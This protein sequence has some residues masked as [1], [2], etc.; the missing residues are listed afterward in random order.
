MNGKKHL[1]IISSLLL[2]LSLNG[3]SNDQQETEQESVV[4]AES[5]VS[6]AES[7]VVEP[8]GD[9]STANG[10]SASSLNMADYKVIDLSSIDNLDWL[11][12]FLLANTSQE[13][14]DEDKVRLFSD[15]YN[16][17]TDGFKKKDM[18][19][20]LLPKV[21]QEIKRYE[22]ANIIVKAPIMYN[23]S[24]EDEHKYR[25]EQEEKGLLPVYSGTAS[26]NNYDFD[27]EGFSYNCDMSLSKSTHGGT[28]ILINKNAIYINNLYELEGSDKNIHCET[29]G[30]KQVNGYEFLEVNDEVLAR[31]IEKALTDGRPMTNLAARGDAYY[32]LKVIRNNI[33]A[34]PL[35]ANVE[36]INKE[37]KESLLKKQLNF[38]W[39]GEV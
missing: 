16:S 39:D 24:Y 29:D 3:C 34:I 10:F 19:N 13:V 21:K 11:T 7:E 6:K 2:V 8:N 18:F 4:E 38:T 36:Y 15:E 23:L 31:K 30:L 17:E 20:E 9:K 35:K 26:L 14:T 32:V 12:P 22:N 33:Y 5:E 37:T 25:D 1:I 27:V 28:V